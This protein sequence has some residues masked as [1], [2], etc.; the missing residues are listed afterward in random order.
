M[1]CITIQNG[2]LRTDTKMTPI[3]D[4]S[5]MPK[6]ETRRMT[7]AFCEQHGLDVEKGLENL[8]IYLNSPYVDENSSFHLIEGEGKTLRNTNPDAMI[9]GEVLKYI[10]IA[11]DVTTLPLIRH[12]LETKGSKAMDEIHNL[13]ML[14]AST[15]GEA[16]AVELLFITETK[17]YLA[18]ILNKTFRK[19]MVFDL[20]S[21]KTIS[22]GSGWVSRQPIEKIRECLLKG[23]LESIYVTE[24]DAL[25]IH[26]LAPEVDMF[27]NG[28]IVEIKL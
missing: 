15:K 26:R 4:I 8:N 1:T 23:D 7:I 10:A 20:S 12:A 16:G 17:A 13:V 11:G 25:E 2:I 28:D 5:K 3:V 24:T 27:S 9:K 6:E 18:V 22:I 21:N 14:N 19:G